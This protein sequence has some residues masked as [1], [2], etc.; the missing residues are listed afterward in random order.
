MRLPLDESVPSKLKLALPAHS[1]RTVVEMGW[2]GVALP[3]AIVVLDAVSNELPYLVPRMP[4]LERM[5]TA[6]PARAYA[7]IKTGAQA[8]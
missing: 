2:S 5:L 7:R 8:S 3:V 4:Q 1:V 6:L